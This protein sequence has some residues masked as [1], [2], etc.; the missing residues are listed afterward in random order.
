MLISSVPSTQL[1]HRDT[2]E[3]SEWSTLQ[4]S[5]ASWA[6]G[7]SLIL[8]LPAPAEGLPPG[9]VQARVTTHSNHNGQ[10]A[11]PAAPWQL[12]RA[13]GMSLDLQYAPEE[14]KNT[15]T[16][17]AWVRGCWFHLFC[18]VVEACGWDQASNQGHNSCLFCPGG[19]LGQGRRV[20]PVCLLPERGLE[21]I[22]IFF[23][24]WEPDLSFP[25][26]LSLSGYCWK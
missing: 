10:P 6:S 3:W 11:G 25:L 16:Q 7:D 22:N 23:F 9:P 19:S 15:P 4:P 24:Y 14:A 5:R 8:W 12:P 1:V 13:A 20:L 21:V 26:F 17:R 2:P 18:P